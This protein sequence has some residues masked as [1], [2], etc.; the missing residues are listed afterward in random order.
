VSPR[1]RQRR[2]NDEA[3]MTL[4]EH[5]LELRTRLVRATIALI[6]TTVLSIA[7]TKQLIEFLIRP[8]SGKHPVALH[9]T[10][11]IIIYFKVALISGVVLA[12]PVIVYE[13]L[14]FI[15]PGLTP[16]ERRVVKI[17]VPAASVLFLIGVLFATLVML[18]FA[19]RYLQGFLASTITPTY[20]I[21]KYISFVTTV[22]FWMGVVFETPLI[23]AFLAWMGVISP[24]QLSSG[25]RYAIVL[26]AIIAAVIT[27]TPDP[28]NMTIVMVP[29]LLL[30]EIGVILAK[31]TY[32]ERQK[33]RSTVQ[34]TEA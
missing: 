23:I 29:L 30:Y 33:K 19:I 24:K 6:I 31:I 4:I 25:R 21:D 27:P 32:R 1:Q 34:S 15:L 10:E 9:P 26:I 2:R 17:V 13:L 28:V 3:R 8:M 16:K 12:M 20:S 11:T 5:L 7:F 22:M 18:P 14:M